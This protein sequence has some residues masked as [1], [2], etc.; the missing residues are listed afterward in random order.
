MP[1]RYLDRREA[2]AYLTGQRGLRISHNTLQKMATVGG[3]PSYR[4]FGIRAVYTIEDLE[5]WAEAKLG[6][7]R[8]STSEVSPVADR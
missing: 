8:N 6:R 5:A 1:D 2:A 4:V 7:K 3:G